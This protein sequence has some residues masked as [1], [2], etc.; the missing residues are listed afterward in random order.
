VL[1][2][3]D[4]RIDED[5][6]IQRTTKKRAWQ[7]ARC[8]G[9][10]HELSGSWRDRC[11]GPR[12]Y[13]PTLLADTPGPPPRV[14]GRRTPYSVKEICDIVGISRNTYYKYTRE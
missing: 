6:Y 13:L 9:C 2:V 1:R 8:A 14:I 4:R 10:K 3:Y 7:G 5:G 11:F 12:L